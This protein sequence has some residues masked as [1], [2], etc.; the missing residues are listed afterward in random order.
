MDMPE[1]SWSRTKRDIEANSDK[2]VDRAGDEEDWEGSDKRKRSSKL[3]RHSNAEEADE[4]DSGGRRK[5]LGDWVEIRKRSGGSSRAGSGDEEN[6]DSRKEQRSKQMKKSQEDRTE[7]KSSNGYPDKEFETSKK[8]RDTSGSKGH[9]LADESERS[10]SRKI[11]SKSSVHEDSQRKSRSKVESPN[12]G[13]LEK[14]QDRGSRFSDRKENYREKNLGSREQ[15]RNPRRRWDES[16]STRKTDEGSFM[17]K[18]DSKSGKNLDLK[19]GSTRD[20]AIDARDVS[21]ELKSKVLDFHINKGIKSS[22]REEKRVDGERSKSRGRT[23]TRD[24]DTRPSS[25]TR[26][27]RSGDIRDDKQR[28]GGEKLVGLVEDVESGAHRSSSRDHSEKIEKQRHQ[29]D[30]AQ[31]NREI[32]ESR[33]RSGNTD[34]DG[35]AWAKDRRGRDLRHSKRSHSP[36]RSGRRRLES[37]DSDSDN[38]RSVSLKGREREKDGY[39]DDRVKGRDSGWSD[40]N[41]DWESSKDN[42]KKRHYSGNDKEMRDGDV[43]FNHDKDWDLQKRERERAENEKLPGR[44]GFRKD[45]SRTEG[46]KNSSS[47]GTANENSDMIEIQTKSTDYGREEPGLTFIGRRTDSGQDPDFTSATSDEDWGYLPDDRGR[48]AGTYGPGDD[49][50]DR[51]P[52]DGSPMLDQDLGRNNVDMQGGKGRVQKGAMGF[53]RNGGVQSSSNG[54]QPPFGNNQGSGSFNRAVLQGVKWNRLGRGGRGRPPGRDG[55]RVGMPLP[56]MGS[57]FGPIGLPPAALQSLGPSMSPGPGAPIAPGVFIPSFPGPVVWPGPRGVD[58]NMLAVTPG[59][60][61]VPSGASGPRFAPNMG[62][63]PNPVMYYNQPGPVRGAPPNLPGPGF[64]VVGTMGR[65]APHDKAPVTWVPPRS[66]GPPGKAPSRGEQNDYSQN[67]VDTGM[68]PQNFIRELELTAVVEDYPK[69]RELIQ[70]KDEIVAKSSSPPM[71]YKCDLNEFVLS[72]EFFGTK[73]DV[74]LVDPPWE[75]YVHRAPGVADHMEY[76]TFEEILNLKIEAIADTPSFIF[77]WVGDGVGLEQGRQCLKKWGFRRCEDICWVKTNKTN[78]MP[79][80]RHDSHT[81]FQHSKEHCLMGIKGTVRRSTDGHI[82][83]ANIDTDI[84]IAEEPPYGST[85]KPEDLYQIIEHFSLGR[86]RIELFGED[87]NIRSGWLTVGKG[88]SSSDFNNEAYVRSFADKD[89]KVWQGGGGRNPPPDAPH[90]VLTTPEIEALRP[91]SPPHKNQQQQSTS[92]TQTTA[93]SANK[94]PSGNSPQNPAALGLNQEASSSNPQTSTPWASP[95]GSL[96]GLDAGNVALE[97]KYFDNYGYIASLGL[98]SGDHL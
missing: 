23:E 74:I 81:L 19:H 40:R 64:N 16:D 95:V 14:M 10:S 67:F 59:L 71:Y 20:R 57:P 33:E 13:E 52:D 28:R 69:L 22:S 91:K 17:D 12:D 35:H 31:S 70:K 32:A 83:H 5:S 54:S 42:W 45:R 63:G 43:D 47:F 85:K 24:E 79:G 53:T 82:I 77:L 36:D 41:R 65:G 98:S 75:E 18:S 97:D 76:W 3:K 93:N 92:L 15:E 61:P 89:G 4:W 37:D 87:H 29:R 30:P 73:F 50:Q 46:A 38:E 51:Y 58:I 39:R 96:K 56:M 27:E 34:E 9:P 26:E 48:I 80:L 78:A 86:R 90:L 62:G 60:S 7:K 49:P 21:S 2:K 1:P 6:Y 44:P 25:T 84:I 66:N 94:R 11:I 88:L 8:G 68:R 72:P 55:Q